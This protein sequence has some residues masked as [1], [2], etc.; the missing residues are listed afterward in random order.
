MKRFCL[1]F[2]LNHS[3]ASFI[4]A[5]NLKTRL[6]PQQSN[7]MAPSWITIQKMVISGVIFLIAEPH[8]NELFVAGLA[9]FLWQQPCVI[10]PKFEYFFFSRSLEE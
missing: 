10:E 8:S 4:S 9:V 6:T 1:T 2:A 3:L 5:Q 7:W